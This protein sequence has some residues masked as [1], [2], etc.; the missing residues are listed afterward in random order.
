MAKLRGDTKCQ[1]RDPNISID[2]A[3]FNISTNT[4]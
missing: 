1:G 3:G 2:W 4:V